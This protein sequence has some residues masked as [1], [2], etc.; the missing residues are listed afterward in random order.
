MSVLPVVVN[1]GRFWGIGRPAKRAGTITVS[2][3]PPLPPGLKS[4]EMM[5]RAEQAMEAER[6]RI[7]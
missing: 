5:E 1:S 2:C 6:R 3:L 4:G 7:G